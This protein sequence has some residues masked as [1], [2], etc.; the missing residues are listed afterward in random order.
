MK[1]QVNFGNLSQDYARYRDELPARL[2]N[3]LEA[4]GALN[5]GARAVDLGARTESFSRLGSNRTQAK[6]AAAR[7]SVRRAAFCLIA[8]CLSLR[9]RVPIGCGHI[10]HVPQRDAF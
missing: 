6:K 1:E 2:A 9:Y 5:T 10:P 8:P 3:W 7:R 4:H